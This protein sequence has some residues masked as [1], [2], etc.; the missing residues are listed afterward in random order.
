MRP[1]TDDRRR[2]GAAER[3]R[4][5]LAAVLLALACSLAL[6]S[7][8]SAAYPDTILLTNGDRLKGEVKGL[9]YAK[10]TFKTDAASTIYIKWDRVVEIVAPAYFE[11]E[12]T[13]GVRYYGSIGAGKAPGPA[14]ARARRSGHRAAAR[15]RRPDPPAEAAVL[16]PARRVGQ[17]RRQLHQFERHRPG[18]VERVGDDAPPE[19]QL[20]DDARFDHHR[21]ARTSRSRRGSS[22]ASRTSA[23][24]ASRWFA[25][26][27]RQVRA[28]HRTGHQAAFVGRRRRA[29][30]YVL[31]TNRTV[32]YWSGGLMLN[33]EIP[34]EGERTDNVEA[35]L[36]ASYSF[37]TY[38]T[39][40]TN[41]TTSFVVV[42]SLTS[43][44]VASA[45]TST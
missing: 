39:P 28:E 41:L 26:A 13:V 31:Q 9:E 16:G 7:A 40:K 38:D 22:S 18:L 19:V 44:R 6:A 3:A 23:C 33:R 4:K 36:G 32:M 11:V 30:G 5:A 42:P 21:P 34:I 29:A 10:L 14:D 1:E 37:F 17:P 35:F 20:R 45:P 12:T 24:C 27:E 2:G 15:V 8:A 43:S 25:R